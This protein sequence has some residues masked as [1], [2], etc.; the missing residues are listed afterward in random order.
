MI[1]K[2]RE[3]PITTKVY[4]LGLFLCVL[5]AC[6]PLGPQPGPALTASASSAPPTGTPLAGETPTLPPTPS[7][8]SDSALFVADVTVADNTNLQPGQAFRKTWRLR[9]TGGCAW[10]PD[11]SLVFSGGERMGSPGQVA[12]TET[13]PGATLD[14]SVDLVAP[15]NDGAFTGLYEIHNPAGKAIPIGLTTILWVKITVGNVAPPQAGIPVATATALVTGPGLPVPTLPA[16]ARPKGR[17]KPEPNG[18]YAAQVL[19]L[20]NGARVAAGLPGLSVNSALNAS[21]QA[22]SDDMACHN[23]LSH[24]GS[25][26]SSIYARIVAAGYTPSNWGEIIFASGSAQQAFDWWMND[27]PHRDVILDP[28]LDDFGAGFSYLA[29]SEYGSYYTVDFGKP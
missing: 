19:T 25:D 21:A 5:S 7:N 3:V 8:C 24:T 13:A 20:I 4:R 14:L 28:K 15:A 22:H 10:N 27:K 17:C 9:N 18:A 1:Y 2:R 11:Y 23:L 12:L 16:A 6:A 26:G 29:G